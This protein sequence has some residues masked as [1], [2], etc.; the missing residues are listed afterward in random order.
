LLGDWNC[1]DA[2]DERGQRKAFA[3]FLERNHQLLARAMFS[4]G[5]YGQVFTVRT[6]GSRHPSEASAGRR[7]Q[8]LFA[9]GEQ[10][11]R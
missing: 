3:G 4:Y 10:A 9:R 1:F 5:P 6:N 7:R 11:A 8:D 2:Y